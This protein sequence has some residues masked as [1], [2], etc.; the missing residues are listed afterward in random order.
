MLNFK[1]LR[2]SDQQDCLPITNTESMTIMEVKVF[3]KVL[4]PK[5][6]FWPRST[7]VSNNGLEGE[8]NLWLASQPDIKILKITQS[9]SGG[10]WMPATLT[11]SVWYQ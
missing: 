6:G 11:I 7:I 5:Q 8:I 1:L 9:Q 4:T 3:T 10:S 2:S